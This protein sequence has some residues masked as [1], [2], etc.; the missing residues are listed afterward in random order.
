MCEQPERNKWK[1]LIEL[2]K[3]CIDEKVNQKLA[4]KEFERKRQN[5][6]YCSKCGN[7]I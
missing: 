3:E 5:V 6:G 4:D 2:L 7:K 1:Q